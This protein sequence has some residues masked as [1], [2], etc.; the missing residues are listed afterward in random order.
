M[1]QDQKVM[2]NAPAT[3]Y[4]ISLKDLGSE[5]NFWPLRPDETDQDPS[6]YDMPARICAAPSIEQCVDSVYTCAKVR[7][8][9]RKYGAKFFIYTFEGEEAAKFSANEHV[10][11]HSTT[12][13]YISI[14]RAKAKRINM[15]IFL[16]AWGARYE[17]YIISEGVSV[18]NVRK[19]A[20]DD[21]CFELMPLE[22]LDEIEI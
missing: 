18:E 8:L 12:E 6:E 17:K 10:Y 9:V 22:I 14:V 5:C 1:I 2:K 20:S 16:P 7:S 15:G 19:F 4:H 21:K 3:L 13:E 11:D